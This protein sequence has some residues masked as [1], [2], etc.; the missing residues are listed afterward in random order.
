MDG[1]SLNLRNDEVF[2]K[3]DSAPRKDVN[4]LIQLQKETNANNIAKQRRDSLN[5]IEES[6]FKLDI[7]EE[8]AA[9]YKTGKKNESNKHRTR[10][11]SI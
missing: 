7:F 8:A 11:H 2:D 5:A 6:L 1:G 9:E 4:K 10:K 3:L